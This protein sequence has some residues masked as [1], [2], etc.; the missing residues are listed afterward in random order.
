MSIYSRAVATMQ[1]K[2]YVPLA[3]AAADAVAQ[4]QGGMPPQGAPMPP[5]QG[6][7]MP[8]QGA[9]MPPQGMPPMPPEQMP[10]QGD[11]NAMPPQG[12][13]P[14]IQTVPGPDGMPI[15]VETGFIVLDMQQ[16]IEQ[17]PLTGILFNKSLMEFATPDGQP[18]DPNQAIQM[19]EQARAQQGGQMPPQG[20]PNAM[21]PADPS[22]QGGA[23]MPPPMDP[24]AM[25][26]QGAPMPPPQQPPMQQQASAEM[27]M[28]PNMLGVAMD[29]NTGMPLDPNTGMAVDPST[30]M[31]VGGGQAS[32]EQLLAAVPGLQDYLTKTPQQ[33]ETHEKIM[34]KLQQEVSGFRT[35]LQG[36]RREVQKAN[37]NTDTTAARMENILALVEQLLGS[38]G[39]TTEPLPSQGLP[40]EPTM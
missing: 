32:A 2:A 8:P 4:Q 37:D 13:M 20:D 24:N 38:Q 6:A 19:I 5:P 29:P 7:P 31:P 18:L 3:P 33:L 22:M 15:D 12:Q 1:K 9:P 40:T 11:P 39:M 35:D 27:G 30:G 23:P 36:L 10:P 17:D 34:T 25:P 14:P 16:G 28:D 26:P 21:P